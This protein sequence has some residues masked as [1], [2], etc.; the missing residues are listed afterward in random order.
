MAFTFVITSAILAVIF[1]II[2]LIWPKSLNYAIAIW[3]L[4]YGLFEIIG[5]Y[6]L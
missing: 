5:S 2:I 1:G 6:V 4:V 3:L